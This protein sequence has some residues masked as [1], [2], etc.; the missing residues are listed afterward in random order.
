MFSR[1]A[2]HLWIL[3]AALAVVAAAFVA[4]RGQVVPPSFG[5]LGRYRGAAVGQLASKPRHNATAHDCK[6]CHDKP[7]HPTGKAHAQVLCVEC[8]GEGQIHR[9]DCA[10]SVAAAAPGAV[11]HCNNDGM[12]PKAVKQICLHCHG[13]V[14]GRPP[15]FPQIGFDEHMKDNEPKDIASPNV[16]L[17]CHLAHDPNEEPPDDDADQPAPA[18]TAQTPTAAGTATPTE[19][20]P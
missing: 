13:Q 5:E 2:L 4:V 12:V 16:C 3:V 19:D 17:Q 1:D 18:P 20:D 9:A 7:K 8:H 10:I 11:V 15:K 14:V 6:T